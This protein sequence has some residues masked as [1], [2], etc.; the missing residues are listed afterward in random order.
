MARFP[1]KLPPGVYRN[2]TQLQSKGRYYAASLTRFYQ[3]SVRP[4]GGWNAH[5]TSPVTGKPR[6][7]IAW[8]D[9]SAVTWVAIG[10]HTN[11]YAMSRS[12]A[13]YDITPASF[14][15]GRADATTGGGFGSGTFG[16]GTFGTVR[17]DTTLIM[18][19]SVWSFDTFGQYLDGVMTEDGKIYEWHLDTGVVAAPLSNAPTCASLFTT[20]E[21]MLVALGAESVPR[22]IKWSDQELNTV[23]TA[24]ATNQAGDLD[25]QTNGRLMQ[26]KKIRGTHIVLTDVDAWT[27]TY[28]GDS[29]VYSI[30]K[31][32]EGCGAISRNCLA[33]IDARAVW[34]GRNNFWLYNGFTQPLAC[35]VQDYV[36]SDINLQQ[37]SKV[38]CITNAN[39]SEVKWYYPSGG[40]TE[41]DRYVIWNYAEDHWTIGTLTRLCG[42]DA[43]VFKFPL[44]CATD[45]YVYDHEYGYSY[46]GGAAPYLETGPIELGNG[47]NVLHA[48]RLFPDDKTAGDVSALF[49]IRFEPDGPETV[50]GPYTLSRETDVRFG[51]REVR[52]RYTGITASDWRVGVPHLE[53]V[54]GG[55]R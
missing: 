33:S 40:S 18:D 15:T 43:G 30:K 45:G 7:L 23:W 34:M 9:N 21:G 1:L 52:V 5:S 14:T 48:T 38:V 16:T 22:R 25:L 39:F 8:K 54:Q 27:M 19:A 17:P 32:G 50:F 12:G 26:G 29:L 11:L 35:D 3:G 4:M 6:A 49:Y 47:D 51:G 37:I 44:E 2:G 41:V 13:L 42:A 24:D 31:A 53:M 55:L 46:V 36:F 10:T 28:T 20:Q